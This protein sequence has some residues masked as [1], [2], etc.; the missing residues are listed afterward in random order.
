[1]SR[2]RSSLIPCVVG[3]CLLVYSNATAQGVRYGLFYSPSPGG[4]SLRPMSPYYRV[5]GGGEWNAYAPQY[6]SSFMTGGQPTYL[7]SINYPTI[8]GAYGYQYAPGRL[9]YGLS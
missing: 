9:T 7:T 5:Y 8:Y 1:M 4:L 6:Y 2:S 3:V